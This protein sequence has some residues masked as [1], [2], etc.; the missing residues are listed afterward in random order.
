ME[1]HPLIPLEYYYEKQETITR[2]CLLALKTIVLSI[3]EYGY[4]YFIN[5]VHLK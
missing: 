5:S 4:S 2:E 3:D 1:E